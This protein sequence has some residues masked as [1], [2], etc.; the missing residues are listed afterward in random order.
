M[1]KLFLNISYFL[2]ES[3]PK[4]PHFEKDRSVSFVSGIVFLNNI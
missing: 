3:E 4:S 2:F 1:K